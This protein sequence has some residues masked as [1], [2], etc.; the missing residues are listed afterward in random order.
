MGFLKIGVASQCCVLA[1]LFRVLRIEILGHKQRYSI[2]YFHYFYRCLASCVDSA[3]L[4]A[5]VSLFFDSSEPL[6]VMP[7][8]PSELHK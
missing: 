2:P 3:I 4:C 5:Y 8:F 6:G 1:I 7:E